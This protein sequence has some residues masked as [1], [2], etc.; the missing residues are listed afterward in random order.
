MTEFWSCQEG[1]VVAPVTWR[2][3]MRLGRRDVQ[4]TDWLTDWLSDTP[5]F[6]LLSSERQSLAAF[7]GA[8]RSAVRL[9]A[10]HSCHSWLSV[11]LCVQVACVS[12]CAGSDHTLTHQPVM[13]S[14][15]CLHQHSPLITVFI[16][17]PL[18]YVPVW[19]ASADVLMSTCSTC[20]HRRTGPNANWL[21]LRY[22]FFFFAKRN[23]TQKGGVSLWQKHV[24][25]CQTE[26]FPVWLWLA[27]LFAVKREHPLSPVPFPT[28]LTP[29]LCRNFG[30]WKHHFCP[31]ALNV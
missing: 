15:S 7:S 31:T 25:S 24:S 5:T 18:P 29:P 23:V 17:R 26:S 11:C 2:S 16:Q 9:H 4:E 6:F 22:H 28:Q 21:C 14:N 19:P 3:Q 27:G 30:F 10:E 12:V 8:T 20:N 13:L 1:G